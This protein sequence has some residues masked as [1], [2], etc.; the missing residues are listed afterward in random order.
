MSQIGDFSPKM[1]SSRQCGGSK[2]LFGRNHSGNPRKNL[3]NSIRKNISR[4]CTLNQSM[5]THSSPHSIDHFK[6]LLLLC[7]SSHK[8]PVSRLPFQVLHFTFD[9]SHFTFDV[10]SWI[11]IHPANIYE[12]IP[13][14]NNKISIF[15]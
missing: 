15:S 3:L 2:Q 6:A 4:S 7:L 10:C 14:I 1:R 11:R 12:T 9:V 8:L 13:H 5:N